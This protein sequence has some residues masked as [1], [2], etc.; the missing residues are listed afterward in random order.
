MGSFREELA[1]APK[2]AAVETPVKQSPSLPATTSST[3]R[4][5]KDGA[6]G[7]ENNKRHTPMAQKVCNRCHKKG[8]I[9]ANCPKKAEEDQRLR[10]EGFALAQA[11]KNSEAGHVQKEI[12]ELKKEIVELK[13]ENKDLKKENR[14]NKRKLNDLEDKMEAVWA[15]VEERDKK[16]KNQE[17]KVA[18]RTLALPRLISFL[19]KTYNYYHKKGHIEATCPKKGRDK[20]TKAKKNREKSVALATMPLK[21]EIAGLNGRLLVTEAGVRDAKDEAV[22]LGR[23]LMKKR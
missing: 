23:Q 13:K 15:W 12:S 4:P 8:H 20:E 11:M 17:A 6:A 1:Q 10:T 18:H 22:K 5:A 21:E 9:Q 3:K 19:S 14:E 16:E 2:T 7:N